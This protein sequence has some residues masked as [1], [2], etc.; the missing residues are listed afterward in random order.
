[1]N[2]TFFLVDLPITF[3]PKKSHHQDHRRYHKKADVDS[4]GTYFLHGNGCKDWVNCLTCPFPPETCKW[5]P[6]P[7]SK[8]RQKANEGQ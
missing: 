1:M 8:K 2:Q 3:S 7:K 5:Q 4:N 6:Y